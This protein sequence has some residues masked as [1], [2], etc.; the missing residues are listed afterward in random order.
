MPKQYVWSDNNENWSEHDGPY[1]TRAQAIEAARESEEFIEGQ[2]IY[3]ARKVVP[4][5]PGPG[6]L[7][8]VDL[9]FDNFYDHVGDEFSL[10]CVENWP[11][12]FEPTDEQKNVFEKVLEGAWRGFLESIGA[13]PPKTWWLVEDVEKV[14]A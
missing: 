8:D 12:E 9:M 10:E 1:E 11:S 7:F 4:K 5:W 14:K 3:T 6:C 2:P 13:W